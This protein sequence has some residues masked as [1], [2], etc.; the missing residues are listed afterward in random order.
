MTTMH[1]DLPKRKITETRLKGSIQMLNESLVSL[2]TEKS[3]DDRQYELEQM[4]RMVFKLVLI[5]IPLHRMI[6]E[7]G[8]IEFFVLEQECQSSIIDKSKESAQ[9]DLNK[10]FESK[11][12]CRTEP[13]RAFLE[14]QVESSRVILNRLEPIHFDF[15]SR[16]FVFTNHFQSVGKYYEYDIE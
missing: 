11:E 10:L 16:K 3:A 1:E 6:T 13:R 9:A 7:A 15:R 2:K 8:D 4:R 12:R 5:G 14:Q